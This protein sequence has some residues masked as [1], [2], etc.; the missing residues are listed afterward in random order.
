MNSESSGNQSSA[1]QSSSPASASSPLLETA[2]RFLD[3]LSGLNPAEYSDQ[4]FY[5]LTLDRLILMTR[6]PLAVLW[7]AGPAQELVPAV[8][9]RLDARAALPPPATFRSWSQQLAIADERRT[10]Q[11]LVDKQPLLVARINSVRDGWRLLTLHCDADTS[12][13]ALAVHQDLLGVIA[14]L[15]E[16]FERRR[17]LGDQQQAIEPMQQMMALFQNLQSSRDLSVLALHI[18]NDARAL[19]RADRVWLF[20]QGVP[21][22]LLAASGVAAVEPRS[23]AVQGMSRLVQ[24]VQRTR[25]NWF[26]VHDRPDQQTTSGPLMKRWVE[27]SELQ[28]L[29]AVQILEPGVPAKAAQPASGRLQAWLMVEYRQAPEPLR[30]LVWTTRIV[31]ASG[32]PLH[33]A[34]LWQRLP[35]RRALS[36]AGSA[37]QWFGWR[38]L[39]G[40]VATLLAVSLLIASLFVIQQDFQIHVT[41]EMRPVGERHLFAPVD[42]VVIEV[43]AEYG[44]QVAAG[45]PLIRMESTE[46]QLQQQ[47]LAARLATTQQ[48][49][50]Q[51]Q[52]RLMQERRTSQDR[53]LP[54]KIAADI[55]QLKLE[56]Q[57][58]EQEVA[59]YEKLQGELSVTSPIAGQVISRDRR[60]LLLGRPVSRGNVLATISSTAGSWRLIC[61]LDDRDAGYLQQALSSGEIKS[62]LLRFKRTSALDREYEVSLANVEEHNFIKADGSSVIR[63][64]AGIDELELASLRVGETVTGQI[65]CGRRSLFFLWTRDLKDLLKRKFWWPGSNHP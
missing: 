33:H 23:E 8:L 26:W 55:E 58:I 40:T 7:I 29:Q 16:E 50:E 31:E 24:E 64:L 6:A 57:G 60:Q 15:S 30:A 20:E 1:G 22:R 3:E 13:P 34:R 41:G 14:E 65:F 51:N 32:A 37:L 61:E 28:S 35:F 63:G 53:F 11:Q 2:D 18:V 45:Q 62:P 36:A 54:E 10:S 12:V 56:I 9:S 43:L 39:P 21:P 17:Q 47:Q 52:L 42:G 46:Y 27:D 44:D 49:L 38:S 4:R 59:A 25:Q 19:L 5:Q 48:Q